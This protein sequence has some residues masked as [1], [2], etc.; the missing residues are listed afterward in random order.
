[1]KNK[2]RKIVLIEWV[3]A[4]MYGSESYDTSKVFTLS[5][6]YASGYLVSEDREKVVIA[7]DFFDHPD[8]YTY[9]G[10]SVYPKTG[11]KKIKYFK[12]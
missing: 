11:I 9:R 5:H 1:M 10:V 12:F 8:G 2:I 7:T 4:A 3:D 6:G